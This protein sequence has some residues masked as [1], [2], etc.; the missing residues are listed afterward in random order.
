MVKIQ[1]F[2]YGDKE[3]QYLKDKDPVFK[4][5][6]EQIGDVKREVIPDLYTALID[7]VIGQQISTK[8]AQTIKNRFIEKFSPITPEHIITI[9]DEQ[10]Q[11]CGITLRKAKYIKQI[12]KKIINHECDLHQLYTLS[13]EDVC[14]ELSKLP[15]IGKWSA[16]MLMLHAMQRPNILSETDLG[17]Q[18]GLRMVYHHRKI[19]P[20]LFH[21][22]QR[23]F[24]PYGSVASLYLWEVSAGAIVELKD[25]G[26][27][28]KPKK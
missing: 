18:R 2:Q 6:I 10:L 13:D 15:G 22:Y 4:E 1:Y 7:A 9:N 19:T 20:Q 14:K 17:I 23:R 28:K 24:S 11:S 21:K 26:A 12:T 5:I 27:K 8:A 16:E 3:R 25:L